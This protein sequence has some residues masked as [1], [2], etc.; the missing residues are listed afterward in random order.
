[1]KT[2]P[3]FVGV[4]RD[5]FRGADT[6]AVPLM[7]HAASSVLPKNIGCINSETSSDLPGDWQYVRG[8]FEL[9]GLK[10]R[11]KT[12]SG[13]LYLKILPKRNLPILSQRTQ[14]NRDVKLG[15]F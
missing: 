7:L 1:M 13:L 6:L 8:F 5:L 3:G 4:V 11:G 2:S 15:Y 14:T 9:E 12:S 10:K